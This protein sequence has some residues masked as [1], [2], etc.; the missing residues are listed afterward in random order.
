[1]RQLVMPPAKSFSRARSWKTF[2][3]LFS[4]IEREGGDLLW[5]PCDVPNGADYRYW[6]T[7]LDPMTGGQLYLTPGFRFVN[8]LGYIQC[9]NGWGGE[10]LSHPEYLY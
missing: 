4:P 6:W 9:R 10:D 1:M 7:V 3:N 2:E 8:R 5:E